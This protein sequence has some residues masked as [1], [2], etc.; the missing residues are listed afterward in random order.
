M[1]KEESFSINNKEKLILQEDCA[2]D[3]LKNGILTLTNKKLIFE[4]TEGKIATLSKKLVGEKVG[5]EFDNIEKVRSEGIIIKKL[6]ITT[7]NNKIYKFGVLSPN[8]WVK[9]IQP[10]LDKYI[11]KS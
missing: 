4:K 5:I 8:N 10:Q 3:V 2:E 11:K 1:D 7:N 9:H 6:V